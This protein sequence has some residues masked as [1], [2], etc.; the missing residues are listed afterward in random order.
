M[1][2]FE[3]KRRTVEEETFYIEVNGG[4]SDT[5]MVIAQCINEPEKLQNLL[6]MA[7]CKNAVERSTKNA[8][9]SVESASNAN[10]PKVVGKLDLVTKF[11]AN[12]KFNVTHAFNFLFEVH[13]KSRMDVLNILNERIDN[14]FGDIVKELDPAMYKDKYL[15]ETDFEVME[16]SP[17]INN[18]SNCPTHPV[19][20][21]KQDED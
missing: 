14:E 20:V 17:D 8:S 15:T 2:V 13:A 10:K 6:M 19:R 21:Y 5:E 11:Y 9:W 1:A 16:W 7:N 18:L 4:G 3:V 12:V